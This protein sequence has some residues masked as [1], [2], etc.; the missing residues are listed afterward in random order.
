MGFL[1]PFLCI[2]SRFRTTSILIPT[3]FP[4]EKRETK[5]SIKNADLWSNTY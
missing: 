1:F 3:G 2:I 5:I 4:W